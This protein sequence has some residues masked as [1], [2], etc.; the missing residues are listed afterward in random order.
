MARHM[1]I[2]RIKPLEPSSAP[3]VT[4]SLLSS[5]KPMATAASPAY[6]FR[7]EITVGISAPPIGMMSRM[8]K[9]SASTAIT[10]KACR[11]QGAVGLTTSSTPS[12][13]A[14]ASTPTLTKFW[15]G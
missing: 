5:T 13:T 4:S 14:M 2:E 10:M 15:P 6:A 3:A 8:P 12:A 9:I 1:M 7:I 11:A